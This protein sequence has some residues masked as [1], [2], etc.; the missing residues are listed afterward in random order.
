[1]GSIDWIGGLALRPVDALP[2][3][4]FKL[5]IEGGDTAARSETPATISFKGRS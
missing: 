3:P 2:E 5:R 4:H 1:M